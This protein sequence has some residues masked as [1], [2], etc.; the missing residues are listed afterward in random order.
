MLENVRYYISYKNVG[1]GTTR[2][3]IFRPESSGG[4]DMRL[5]YTLLS[6][7]WDTEYIIRIRAE[8]RYSPCNNFVSGS[9]S[10]SVSFR[11]NTTS[12]SKLIKVLQD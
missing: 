3:L 7:I 5:S 12:E 4:S 8:I 2:A 9:Y 6:L 1:S 10:D 11:T